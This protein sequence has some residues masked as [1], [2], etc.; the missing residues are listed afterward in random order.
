M[1]QS[2]EKSFPDNLP[3]HWRN[4]LKDEA[5]QPYFKSL[6][7][8]LVGEHRAKKCIFPHGGELGP[9]RAAEMVD[10]DDVKVV[11]LGQ[12]PYHGEG[13]AIGLSFGVAN[14]LQPKPPS[15]RKHI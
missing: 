5:E 9:A 8:F 10:Y 14:D 12:D 3:P 4:Q 1:E 7:R 6:T 13:Q 15:P 11:I 2:K